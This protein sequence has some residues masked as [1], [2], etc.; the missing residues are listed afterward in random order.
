MIDDLVSKGTDEPYRMFTSR[1][2]HRLLL[3]ES[4][5]DARL[6][7]LGFEHGLVKAG[8]WTLFE[9]RRD[10]LAELTRRLETERARP[11]A[12]LRAL[13]ADMGESPPAE[14]LPLGE[15]F[16]RPHITQLDF[17][18]IWPPFLDYPEDIRREAETAFRYAGYVLRQKEQARRGKNAEQTA[19][20]PGLDYRGIAGL[21]TEAREKLDAIRPLNLGQ[22][23]RIPGVTPAALACLEIALK[24]YG[25]EKKRE[26]S[27]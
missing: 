27:A 10:R 12:A 1:A 5:A 20:P 7:P 26:L 21:T 6:T 16:R 8:Q 23:G 24:K 9:T 3:R 4:N 25:E 11:D 18:R 22:A 17:A 13:F 14:A 2:E 15:L 19:L